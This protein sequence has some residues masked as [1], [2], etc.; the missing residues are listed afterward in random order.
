MTPELLALPWKIQIALVAGYAAYMLAYLGVRKYH[1]A[2]DV[3]FKTIAFSLVASAVLAVKCNISPFYQSTVAIFTTVLV[4]L[5]WKKWICHIYD[6]SLRKFG[7]NF[8]DHP[9]AWLTMTHDQAH[10]FSQISVLLD[11]GTWLECRHLPNFEHAPLGPAV[12]GPE[13]DVGIY[14]THTISAKGETKELKTTSDEHYGFRMTY[15]P[16]DRIARINVRKKPKNKQKPKIQSSLAG[17]AGG[18]ESVSFGAT[19]G[20]TEA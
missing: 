5:I 15:I 2:A 3:F 18:K 9:T 12:F 17:G 6:K 7:I 11:N 19:D 16:K 8:E 1:T 13:G 4:G 14:I 20:L 10:Y